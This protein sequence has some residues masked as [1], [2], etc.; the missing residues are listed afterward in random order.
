ME[1]M[2][3]ESNRIGRRQPKDL[4]VRINIQL[5][6]WQIEYLDQLSRG[7]RSMIIRGLISDHAAEE[8][9]KQG[10]TIV[11]DRRATRY[12][13]DEV[14]SVQRDLFDRELHACL[15]DGG[16]PGYLVPVFRRYLR[17]AGRSEASEEVIR[18]FLREKMFCLVTQRQSTTYPV[19]SN[20]E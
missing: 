10:E 17:E 3:S 20:T 1:K 6:V 7:S 12:D 8:M 11:G 2:S 9:R 5:P 14:Y 19:W 18:S 13:F 16:D 4:L 15:R